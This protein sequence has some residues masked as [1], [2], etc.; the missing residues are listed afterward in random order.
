M[1]ST[2]KTN[3]WEAKEFKIK[4]LVPKKKSKYQLKTRQVDEFRINEE[5]LENWQ[6]QL[7]A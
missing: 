4:K 1:R 3:N 5:D 6:Q 7:R 2:K